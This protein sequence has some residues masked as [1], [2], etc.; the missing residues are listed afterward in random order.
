MYGCSIRH[1]ILAEQKLISDC[2]Y[3]V[4]K[5]HPLFP[6]N[7]NSSLVLV[8]FR[9]VFRY[10]IK[11]RKVM[12]HCKNLMVNVTTVE[13]NVTTKACH[14]VVVKVNCNDVHYHIVGKVNTFYFTF[15]I[16]ILMW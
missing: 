8:L 16:L 4:I 13:V 7:Q 6:G 11:A 10:E 5:T 12:V 14:Y 1:G 9:E 15:F 3:R 2:R